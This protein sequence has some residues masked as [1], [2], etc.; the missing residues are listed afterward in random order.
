MVHKLFDLKRIISA[1]TAAAML[2]ISNMNVKAESAEYEYI[3]S[4]I[5]EKILVMG[6]S[7]ATGYGLEG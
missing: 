1:F 7:I 4:P 2:F 6:D 5:P 3:D